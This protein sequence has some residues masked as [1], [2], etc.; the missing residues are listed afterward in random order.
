MLSSKEQSA[1][2]LST[3]ANTWLQNPLKPHTRNHWRL[4]LLEGMRAWVPGSC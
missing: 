3:S 2:A 4:Q 1:S